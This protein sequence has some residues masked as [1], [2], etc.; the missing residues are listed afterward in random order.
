MEVGVLCTDRNTH[1]TFPYSIYVDMR[2]NNPVFSDMMA[3]DPDFEFLT[4]AQ[5]DVARRVCAMFVS[6]NYFSFLGFAPAWER[7]FLAEEEQYGAEPV[8]VLS[9]RNWQRQGANPGVVGSQIAINGTF[10]R[11]AGVAPKRFTGTKVMGPDLWLPVGCYGLVGHPGQEK[12]ERMW[13]E[14][15]NYPGVAPVGRLEPGLTASTAQARLQSLVPRLKE[16]RPIW[17]EFSGA[18]YVGRLPKLAAGGGDDTA[19][20]SGASPFLMGVSA[21]VLLIACLNLANMAIVRGAAR[22]LRLESW[23]RAADRA[24]ST[25]G[26]LRPR[27]YAASLRVSGR[28]SEVRA[29]GPDGELV[30]LIPLCG[31]RVRRFGQHR[32]DRGPAGHR[33]APGRLHPHSPGGK[34]RSDGGAEIRMRMER[35]NT[36]MMG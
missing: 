18:L 15:W 4:L 25:R 10:F 34:S 20:L 7:A 19:F 33:L 3:Y 26:R 30:R 2:E 28:P 1:N 27:L 32:C 16:N 5:G 13:S 23:R 11:V 35:W 17:W 21:V 24:R 12:P 29:R 14:Y 31:R 9:Y 36:G 8:A 6:A 22:H